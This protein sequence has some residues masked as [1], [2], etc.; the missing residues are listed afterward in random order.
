M[1]QDLIEQLQNHSNE[2]KIEVVQQLQEKG[3]PTAIP[4]LPLSG[5]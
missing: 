2:K 1:S 3:D 4:A 5:L